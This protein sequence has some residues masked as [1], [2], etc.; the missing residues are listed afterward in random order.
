MKIFFGKLFFLVSL[1]ACTFFALIALAAHAEVLYDVT[2][3]EIGSDVLHIEVKKLNDSSLQNLSFPKENLGGDEFYVVTLPSWSRF[4]VPSG[5]EVD[6]DPRV[7][8]GQNHP[9]E[10]LGPNSIRFREGSIVLLEGDTALA[11]RFHGIARERDRSLIM[12]HYVPFFESP[13]VNGRYAYRW[14]LRDEEKPNQPFFRADETVNGQ[15]KIASYQY[16]LPGV[17]DSRDPD[18]IKYHVALMKMSGVDGV[19]LD[20][21]GIHDNEGEYKAFLEASLELVKILK[22]ANMYF[23]ICYEEYAIGRVLE[24]N[25]TIT[26]LEKVR[27]DFVWLEK[28]WFGDELYVKH[29]ERPVVLGFLSKD[30]Y[31]TKQEW[32]SAFSVLRT[33]PLFLDLFNSLPDSEGAFNW[34]IDSRGHE[35]L[36]GA[37]LQERIKNE[38][39]EFFRRQRIKDYFVATAFPAFDDKIFEEVGQG[40]GDHGILQYDGGETF[41]LTFDL[42]MQA[43]PDII[44]LAVWN[45]H[46]EGT[47]I[48]PTIDRYIPREGM[49]R[50]YGPLDYLQDSRRS[51]DTNFSSWIREDLRAPIEFYKLMAGKCATDVQKDLIEKAYKAVWTG[52]VAEFRGYAKQAVSYDMSVQANLRKTVNDATGGRADIDRNYAASG[53]IV[54]ITP[55][56]PYQLGNFNATYGDNKKIVITP[57]GSFTMPPYEVT[58]E[59]TEDITE[60]KITTISLPNG[61]IGKA[62]SHRLEANGSE[63]I[64]WSIYSGNLPAGLDIN[65]SGEISGAPTEKGTF[66]FIIEAHNS[67]GKDTQDLS[68]FVEDDGEDEDDDEQDDDNGGGGGKPTTPI[69]NGGSGGDTGGGCSVGSNIAV[70]LLLLSVLT[71]ASR[72]TIGRKF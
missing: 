36:S 56:N 72:K 16:P 21:Y 6:S 37:Q 41:K 35:T 8:K 64:E 58:I 13:A 33:K 30:I 1:L 32:D 67:A 70:V 14:T 19:I 54:K 25:S 34:M 18:L 49:D 44:Q 55:K 66:N 23:V 65:N 60:P 40:N 24:V 3:W 38:F 51:W 2:Q 17:Y 10:L 48:E 52:D 53:E 50:G 43:K 61:I 15:A 69:P 47:A 7:A 20:F 11:A 5:W 63:P 71:I 28:N 31:K 22:E 57:K 27:E 59:F 26:A 12:A 68:I 4:T 9:G 45:D 29:E 42:A 62:Y 46:A 39:E